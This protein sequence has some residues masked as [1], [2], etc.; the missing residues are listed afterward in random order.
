MKFER[1]DLLKLY[2]NMVLTRKTD[3]SIIDGIKT[4]RV[5]SFF[6]SGQ[7]HEATDVGGVTFLRKTDWVMSGV[8]G[9]GVGQAI[10]KGLDIRAFIAEHCGRATGCCSGWSGFHTADLKLGLP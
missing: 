8:R 5:V 1:D 3:E 2:R 9:H 7:G 6:H 10:A 4:G